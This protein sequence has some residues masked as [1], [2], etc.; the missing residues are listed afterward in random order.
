MTKAVGTRN[1]LRE[2]A[3][4]QTLAFLHELTDGC[5]RHVPESR[6]PISVPC[7]LHDSPFQ[8]QSASALGGLQKQ[9]QQT[10][11]EGLD[12]YQLVGIF[13]TLGVR[14]TDDLIYKQAYVILAE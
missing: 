3:N 12:H 4:H 11:E 8:L 14:G 10:K 13:W 9:P 7:K 6:L 2:T 1:P 5:I